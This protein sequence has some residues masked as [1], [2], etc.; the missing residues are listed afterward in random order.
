MPRMTMTFRVVLLAVLLPAVAFNPIS[1]QGGYGS[2]VEVVGDEVLV[3]KP[4]YGQGPGAALVYAR[5]I[6]GVWQMVDQLGAE[7]S[8]LTGEGLSPSFAVFGDV[9]FVAAGD[10]DERWG[11]H[12]FRHNALRAWS[13]VQSLP[14]AMDLA[15][16]QAQWN[17]EA[18]VE[19]L[20]PPLRAVDTDGDRALVAEIG[21]LGAV[22][23]FARALASGSWIEWAPL[24]RSESQRDD[25][26]GAS[27]SIR[28]DV[29]IVGARL[30]GESGAAYI[31]SRDPVSGEWTEDVL[32]SAPS[33]FP[34]SGF[35]AAV[36]IDGEAVLIGHP[37]TAES[38][39]GVVEYTWDGARGAWT[40]QDR[41]A[42]RVR[43]I[44][45]R[46]GSSL[47]FLENELLVGAPGTDERR[48]GV[49]RFVRNRSG[50][51]LAGGRDLFSAG[52]RARVR[53]RLD[54]GDW[55]QRSGRRGSRCRWWKGPRR[56]LFAA[57]QR[58]VG[59]G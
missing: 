34:N 32:I 40:E 1:A 55:P 7:G 15:G 23:V 31:F 16:D 47:A 41:I 13:R 46:F 30:H 58:A 35:G 24:E 57:G 11:A 36:A 22:R 59:R 33:P 19:I 39:G 56:R 50:G 9:L 42:P 6:D 37:G 54:G 12:V 21:G 38:R 53:S 18:L 43:T 29:A 20:Q 5:D 14:L 48:G 8:A 25:Q 51:H 10:A 45:D 44:G 52:W 4:R 49:H 27:L 26:F 2:A 3:L 28:G 17:Y